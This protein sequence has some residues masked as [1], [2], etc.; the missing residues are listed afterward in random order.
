VGDSIELELVGR[1]L[2]ENREALRVVFE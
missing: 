2:V 1:A